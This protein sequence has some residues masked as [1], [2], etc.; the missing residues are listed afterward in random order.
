M[1]GYRAGSAVLA[2]PMALMMA[3]LFMG[4]IA[5]AGWFGGIVQNS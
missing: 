1:E 4:S 2:S 5:P 3:S